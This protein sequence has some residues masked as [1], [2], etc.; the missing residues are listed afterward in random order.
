[1]KP[2]L[3][4]LVLAALVVAALGG[5][6]A[7]AWLAVDE[8]RRPSPGPA[9]ASPIYTAPRRAADPGE[10]F[11][12][13]NQLLALEIERALVA[14][15]TQQR[16]TAFNF[17]LPELLHAEP[18]RVVAMVA[19]QQPGEARDALRSEVA[20]LWIVADPAAAV[21]WIKSLEGGERHAAADT[22]VAA[23]AA[24]SAPEAVALADEFGVGRDDGSLEHLVQRWAVEDPAAAARWIDSQ[25][26]GAATE[27]L[28]ARIDLV[29]R[30]AEAAS[31]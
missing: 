17:L 14:A 16:E 1:M 5:I 6:G 8:S 15:D 7:A 19:A 9:V 13:H 4:T 28:R 12:D 21:A 23:I 18:G 26:E 10:K 22:A 25:P 27:Q 30:Q 29:R 24:R 11:D 2:H 20:R 3:V 31:H